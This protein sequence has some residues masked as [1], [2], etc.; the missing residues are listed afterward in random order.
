MGEA[1]RSGHL[2]CVEY[3]LKLPNIEVDKGRVSPLALA[4]LN[5]NSSTARALVE[6]GHA[7]VDALL[8]VVTIQ[9][10]DTKMAN[11]LLKNPLCP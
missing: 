1:T 8:L 11:I 6:K 3:L 7:T 5:K 9:N 4:L 10:G 2:R